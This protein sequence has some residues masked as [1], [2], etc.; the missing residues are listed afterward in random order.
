MVMRFAVALALVLLAGCASDQ[1]PVV[2]RLAGA[3]V[4]G[5]AD[6]VSVL[7]GRLDALPLAV[8]HCAR[9]GRS[10]QFDRTEGDR[11]VFRCLIKPQ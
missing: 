7:G 6:R 4:R 11:S 10:A 3:R 9:Y 1:P 5:D 2:D 8:L